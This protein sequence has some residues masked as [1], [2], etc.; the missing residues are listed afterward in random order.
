MKT[1]K[2]NSLEVVGAVVGI[3][4]THFSA[5]HLFKRLIICVCVCVCVSVC[6]SV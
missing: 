4:N 2:D 3:V 1:L 5:M 6:V